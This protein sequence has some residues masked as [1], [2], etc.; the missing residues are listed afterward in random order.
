MNIRTPEPR[1]AAHNLVRALAALGLDLKYPEA[2]NA[3]AK[4]LGYQDFNALRV[5]A[6]ASGQEGATEAPPPQ[7]YVT[8]AVYRHK[9]GEDLMVFNEESPAEAWRIAL[10]K[11]Y[12]AEEF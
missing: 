3:F 6:E 9:H 11:E 12:W 10:A 4:T 1:S 7:A 5:S 8:V 2:L